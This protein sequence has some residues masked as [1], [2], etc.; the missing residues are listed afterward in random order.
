MPETL[1]IPFVVAPRPPCAAG[2]LTGQTAGRNC[3]PVAIVGKMQPG[4]RR[5]P[6]GANRF[7]FV[8][9]LLSIAKIELSLVHVGT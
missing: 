3:G 5:L 4:S 1:V 2:P 7:R 9:G 6:P 8:A